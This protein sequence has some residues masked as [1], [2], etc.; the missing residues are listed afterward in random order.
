MNRIEDE[1]K[2]A[3]RKV[4]APPGFTDEV[5]RRLQDGVVTNGVR[6]RAPNRFR[7][8]AAAALILAIGGA[9]LFQYRRHI[10]N[11]N[12]AALQR[13]LMALSIAAA[14]VDEAQQKAFAPQRWE[15]IGRQLAAGSMQKAK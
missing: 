4:P 11:R 1:L 6:R 3:L 8:A 13:T 14:R 5:I 2:Q 10:Q 9:G 15:R 12:E 7:M